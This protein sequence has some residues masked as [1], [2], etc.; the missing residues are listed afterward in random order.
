MARARGVKEA[1]DELEVPCGV[2]GR[3]Y[4]LGLTGELEVDK[5][6]TIG[7]VIGHVARRLKTVPVVEL[8]QRRTPRVLREWLWELP[9]EVAADETKSRFLGQEEV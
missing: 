6:V 5:P 2:V 1:G 7:V 4:P 3:V 9:G 8:L